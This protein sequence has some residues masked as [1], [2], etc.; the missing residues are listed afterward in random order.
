MIDL[1][2]DIHTDSN[3]LRLGPACWMW[4]YLRRSRTQGYFVP[5]SGGIDSC[6]TA[7]I[8]FSMCRLVAEAAERGGKVPF[9]FSLR[10]ID[11]IPFFSPDEQVIADARRIVGEPEGTA[12]I[13]SDAREFC[14][15]IFHTCYMGTENSSVETRTRAKDLAQ[16]IGSYHIDLNMDTVVNAVRSLFAFVTGVKPKFK[17][18]GGSAAENLALQNIQ[19]CN[20]FLI[21]L[22]LSIPLHLRIPVVFVSFLRI[23]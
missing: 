9:Q 15:R 19:V 17:V 1:I 21:F 5:L 16:A 7:V 12:Y 22:F 20:Q 2:C 11:C 18:H 13:P 14:G 23:P 3:A 6:A 8:V 10:L 4:D